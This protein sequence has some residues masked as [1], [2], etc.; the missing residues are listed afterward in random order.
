MSAPCAVG[1][2][3]I[4]SPSMREPAVR[5]AASRLAQGVAR[6][7]TGSQMT[8]QVPGGCWRRGRAGPSRPASCPVVFVHSC[9]ALAD[10]S[11]ARANDVCLGCGPRTSRP[12][13]AR[14]R[15]VTTWLKRIHPDAVPGHRRVARPLRRARIGAIRPGSGSR[16]RSTSPNTIGSWPPAGGQL[17]RETATSCS[18]GRGVGILRRRRPRQ[19]HHPPGQAGEHQVKHS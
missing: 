15:T 10:A 7:G 16:P 11:A 1:T 6:R 4:T 8:P 12:L 17:P 9:G 13:A 5:G 18:A 2:G 3:G 19:Q 14:G